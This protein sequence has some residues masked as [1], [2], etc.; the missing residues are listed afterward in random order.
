MALLGQGFRPELG[1]YDYSAITRANEMM[2]QATAN[3]GQQVGA[4]V[5]DYFKA[6]ADD[7][8][9]VKAGDAQ[10]AAAMALFPDQKP[11]LEQIQHS[12][13]DENNSISERAAIAS[14]VSDMINMGVNQMR[15][16]S[17]MLMKQ[18]ELAT[19][20]RAVTAEITNAANQDRRAEATHGVSLTSAQNANYASQATIDALSATAPMQL[21]YALTI[22]AQSPEG[23]KS[24]T[25]DRIKKLQSLSPLAQ[26]QVADRIISQ[27]TPEQKLQ[28]E[29]LRMT[30]ANGVTMEVPSV[31]NMKTGQAQPLS[32]NGAM[33]SDPSGGA[34]DALLPPRTTQGMTVGGSLETP[35]EKLAA[36]KYADEKAT[37]QQNTQV[38]IA[39]GEE[40]VAILDDLYS[41]RKDES[42]RAIETQ[43]PGFKG[44]FGAGIGMRHLPGTDSANAEVKYDQLDA[45]GFMVS[46]QDMKGMGALSNAEGLKASTAYTGLKPKMSEDE[47]KKQIL[48]LRATVL[49]GIERIKSGQLVNPDGTPKVATAPASPGSSDLLNA[50][51][52]RPR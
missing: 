49:K 52:N 7:K 19:N 26:S 43:H 48:T 3:F 27:F 29:N 32:V 38:S 47:A 11:Y 23:A 10:I 14:S 34:S 30:D 28:F 45:K 35:S 37:S 40:M 46:I 33:P 39:K 9:K 8:K 51:Q 22:A 42:G 18:Q 20:E 16:G 15:Y 13:K 17:E 41:S 31:V 50:W 44:L 1:I 36:K 6:Q 25:A 24:M 12:L 5:E 21:D 2:G 4:G